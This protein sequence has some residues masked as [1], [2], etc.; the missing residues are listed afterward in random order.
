MYATPIIEVQT[1]DETGKMTAHNAVKL[2]DKVTDLEFYGENGEP[3]KVTGLIRR[4]DIIANP[5][6]APVPFSSYHNNGAVL[7]TVPIQNQVSGKSMF[8][9]VN[10]QFYI[11]RVVI[12]DIE[13]E[14]K[15]Y[16]IQNSQIISCGEIKKIV[17][18]VGANSEFKTMAEAIGAAKAGDIVMLNENLK[19]DMSSVSANQAAFTLPAGVSFDGNGKEIVVD[20]KTTTT[21]AHAVQVSGKAK[22]SNLKIVGNPKM[23]AGVIVFGDDS[24]VTIENVEV[25][26]C[27][28][29]GVQCAG[30]AKAINLRTSG[31]PWGA[32]NVDKGSS[33]ATDP[34]FTFVSGNLAEPV[35]VYTEITDKDVVT[36]PENFKKVVGKGEHLKGFVY[37]TDDMSK[38]G[39]LYG[40]KDGVTYVYETKAEADKDSTV[41]QKF[42]TK[43]VDAPMV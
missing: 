23:K 17:Q 13:D 9:S 30:K 5:N 15:L 40:V 4:M 37:Y 19:A 32:V 35:Q 43:V 14:T 38:L 2:L 29:V 36:M 25:V 34:N 22:V 33:M 11:D 42:P 12:S 7:D 1:F 20:E 10:Q 18:G 39:V 3:V 26:N 24:D 16:Y 31:N 6:S 8:V 28:S 21:G 27:G 41:A